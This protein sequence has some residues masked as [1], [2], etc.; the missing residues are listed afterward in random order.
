VPIGDT[1]LTNV[2]TLYEG[3]E[4]LKVFA[5]DGGYAYFIADGYLQRV[6]LDGSSNGVSEI[7]ADIPSACPQGGMAAANGHVAWTDVCSGEVYVYP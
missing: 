4:I 6:A 3:N 5:I 2:S 7:A 1:S